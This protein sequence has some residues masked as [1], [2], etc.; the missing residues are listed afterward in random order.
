MKAQQLKHSPIV[1]SETAEVANSAV[2]VRVRTSPSVPADAVDAR[3]A[4]ATVAEETALARALF[5]WCSA[6]TVAGVT[7]GGLVWD[8]MG[9]LFGAVVGSLAGAVGVV[10]A[11]VVKGHPAPQRD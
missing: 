11:A 8:P 7:V 1:Q 6:S 9:A 2:R 5:Y 3:T 10:V 4:P